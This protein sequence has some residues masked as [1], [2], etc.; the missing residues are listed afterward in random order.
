[1]FIPKDSTV[2]V[3]VWAIHHT[4]QIYSDHDTFNPDRYDSHPR[5]ANDYAGSPDWAKRDKYPNP[6]QDAS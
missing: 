2:F 3:A 1:M 5:L 6:T 4:E